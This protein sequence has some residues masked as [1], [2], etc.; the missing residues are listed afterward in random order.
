MLSSANS[1]CAGT[2]FVVVGAALAWAGDDYAF[3]GGGSVDAWALNGGFTALAVAVWLI[4]FG[5]VELVVAH[6][7][8]AWWRTTLLAS[9]LT[10][11]FVVVALVRDSSEPDQ[12]YAGDC[13]VLIDAVL[14]TGIVPV[15]LVQPPRGFGPPRRAV[16]CSIGQH[17][18]LLRQFKVVDVFG[19]TGPQQQ[20][21]VLDSLRR[22][23]Y[24][25]HT[26]RIHIRFWE[27][28]NWGECAPPNPS[29]ARCR[30][31]E[32]MIREAIVNRAR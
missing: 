22:A 7:K 13:A 24:S 10:L 32:L 18:V 4:A 3:E 12:G 1:R 29:G 14:S 6:R 2:F 9:V 8:H 23:R 31:P 25:E 16:A 17:G 26:A 5:A 20:Q 30:G 11:A 21:T 19:V 28:E 15:S 27:K